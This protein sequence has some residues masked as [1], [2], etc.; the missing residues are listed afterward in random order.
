MQK[1]N[2]C[3]KILSPMD[4]EISITARQFYCTGQSGLYDHQVA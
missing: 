1:I 4:Y 3:Y 2:Y